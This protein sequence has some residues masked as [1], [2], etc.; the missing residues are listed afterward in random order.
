MLAPTTAHAVD[1]AERDPGQT[2]TAPVRDALALLPIRDEDRTGYD[3]TKFRHWID[4][5]RDGCNTRAEVL[6]AEAVVAPEQ[7]ARCLLTGGE[8]YSPYDDQYIQGP[9]GLD[10]DHLVPLAE[11]WDSGASTWTAAEREAYANDL[12][13]DRALIAVSAA[14]NRSKADQDPSTW[15]PPAEG[16]RCEYVTDWI[17]DKIRWGLSIDAIEQASLTDVLSRCPDVP[18]TV[19]TAR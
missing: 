8:W 14:S 10:I 13:D 6:K 5:D 18:V 1:A 3:R 2:I 19:T 16:Y 17:A 15:L 12:G 11:A 9:R 7:G 4:A